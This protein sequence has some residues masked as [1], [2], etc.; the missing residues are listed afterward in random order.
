[1]AYSFTEKKRIRKDFGKRSILDVPY[2][3]AIQLDSY[4][5]SCRKRPI[6]QA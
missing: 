2:L 4:R 5:S 6:E 1:M 3:L